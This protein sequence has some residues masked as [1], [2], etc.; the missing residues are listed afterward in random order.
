MQVPDKLDILKYIYE[1]ANAKG[2]FRWAPTSDIYREFFPYYSRREIAKML[3]ELRDEGYA[4]M[5]R[6][7]V[8][9]WEAYGQWFAPIGDT[10]YKATVGLLRHPGY[11][12]TERGEELLRRA[13]K[14]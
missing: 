6:Y 12:V 3:K 10:G 11:R 7:A 1:N 5:S 4:V 2:E 14:I 8:E 13:G 9:H